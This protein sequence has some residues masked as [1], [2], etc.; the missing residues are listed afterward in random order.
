MASLYEVLGFVALSLLLITWL[1]IR[2]GRRTSATLTGWMVDDR[3][4]GPLLTWFLLGTEI[5]TAFTFLGLA[6][7]AYA[8]GAGI[9]YNVGTNDVGYALGFFILPAIGMIGRRFGHVT[10][11][12]FIADRYQSKGLGI[13]VA[14]STAIILIAYI[15]LNIVGLGAILAVLTNHRLNLLSADTIGFAVLTL[16]VFFGGIRG[17]AWQSMVK[18][19][20]M[21]IAIGALFFMVP[22]RFFGGFGSMFHRM[23]TEIPKHI[24]MPGPSGKLGLGWFATTI[25]LT[26]FGQWMW[27][28]WFN[29]AYTARGGRTLKLQA[30]FMPLYQLVKIAVITVGFAAVLIFA[31]HK[32]AGNDVVMLIAKQIFPVWFLAVFA[33]AAVL[34]A[35]VPAG[36]IIMMSCT[37]LAHNVFAKL[38]PGISPQTIFGLSRWLV[39]AV[40]LAAL[41][42]AIVAHALI[43]VILL[44]AYDFIAQLLPGIVIGGLF[45]RRATL[46][47]TAAGLAAGWGLSL[48]F[49]L[50][51]HGQIWHMNSGFVAL[52]ANIIVFV[53]VSLVTKPVP[54]EQ[55]EPFFAAANP[56]RRPSAMPVAAE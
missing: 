53:L 35:I 1:G 45:W 50:T 21:F 11:S 18:D 10:Q 42:L 23:A 20:L 49:L 31:G 52:V 34:S 51:G 22:F 37:L 25:L 55:L 54:A 5:Y 4:M 12:D 13:I 14:F 3:S 36:P 30:V 32:V 56:W 39:F 28:Q 48:A 26:G 47:G 44:V 46:A 2:S 40:T 24:T 43:V 27:P 38:R 9:F 19:I 33:L 8:K 7:F 6:G 15:D 41:I 17:N 16:A 29:V